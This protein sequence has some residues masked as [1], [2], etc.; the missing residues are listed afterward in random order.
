MW[1]CALSF[2]KF[3][4][5]W[6]QVHEA[7]EGRKRTKEMSEECVLQLRLFVHGALLL[8]DEASEPAVLE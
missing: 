6:Q 7:N 4:M 2:F 1:A 5:Q 3:V 8:V